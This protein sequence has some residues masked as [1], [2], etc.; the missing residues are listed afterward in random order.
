MTPGE[1]A[2][3]NRANARGSTGPR[4]AAGKAAA[5]RNALRHGLAVPGLGADPAEILGL[6]RRIA[7]PRASLLVRAAAMDF[8]SAHVALQRV[9]GHRE[10]L[11][12][13]SDAPPERLTQIVGELARLDRYEARARTRR[14]AAIR[15]F[16]S[17]RSEAEGDVIS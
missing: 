11:L 10:S 8:A 6:A 13:T 7:G 9:R 15:A 14:K 12:D 17:I 4:T 5:S 2:A 3:V 1:R 16:D